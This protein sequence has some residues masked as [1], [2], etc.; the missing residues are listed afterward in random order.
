[1]PGNKVSICLM[2]TQC[3]LQMAHF[4]VTVIGQILRHLDWK[5]SP[6]L[7]Q[8]PQ[9][10]GS[11]WNRCQVRNEN[12]SGHRGRASWGI[13]SP[14]EIWSV[15]MDDCALHSDTP[16]GNPPCCYS[17]M[18]SLWGPVTCL[19]ETCSPTQVTFKESNNQNSPTLSQHPLLLKVQVRLP[20][21]LFHQLLPPTLLPLL[22]WQLKFKYK[23]TQSLNLD[24]RF[25]IR[26]SNQLTKR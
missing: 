1:M 14:L 5:M 15:Q 11:E 26:D 25:L 22:F 18:P 17:G 20:H 3:P 7:P 13:A 24:L 19:S 12:I 4:S 16:G 6:E 21:C 8:A 10:D 9:S 23:K 2:K